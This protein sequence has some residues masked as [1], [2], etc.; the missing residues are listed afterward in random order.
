MDQHGAPNP[1]SAFASLTTVRQT[2]HVR[3]LSRHNADPLHVAESS[4]NSITEDDYDFNETTTSNHHPRSIEPVLT[5][6][7]VG[8]TVLAS[9]NRPGQ[10]RSS[11]HLEHRLGLMTNYYQTSNV[12][13]HIASCAICNI[14]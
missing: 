9:L 12:D 3:N 14:L 8:P 4:Y 13:N 7:N 10:I 2:K 5:A 1:P 11:V 6:A